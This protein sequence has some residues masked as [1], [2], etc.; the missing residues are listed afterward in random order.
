MPPN[1]LAIR[2]LDPAAD[3][4]A[5]DAII[6]GL[7]GWF[8]VPEGIAECAVAVRTAHGLV[9]TEAGAV[10]GF[11][12]DERRSASVWEITWM[13]VQADRRGHGIGSQLVAGLIAQLPDVAGLLVVKTL[14]DRDGDTGPEYDATRAFYLTRGFRP[15]AELDLWGPG[16]PCQ[17]LARSLEPGSA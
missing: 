16:D 12:T 8:G 5:C 15:A 11:L 17:L 14:S 2:E 9:A 6:R 4:D 3:T 1:A 10:T 7:P 13:A